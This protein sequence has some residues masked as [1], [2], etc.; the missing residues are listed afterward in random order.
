[1]PAPEDAAARLVARLLADPAYR[2]AFRR[3]PPGVAR[4]AGL[5][6]LADALAGR[7]RGLQRLEVRESRSVLAGAA[8]GVLAEGLAAAGHGVEAST[9]APAEAAAPLPIA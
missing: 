5:P 9:G 6:A 1:M 4:A 2:A 7:P 8:A 3:D